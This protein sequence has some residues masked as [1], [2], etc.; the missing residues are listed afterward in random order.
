MTEDH[1]Q[2]NILITGAAGALGSAV[3]L[4]CAEQGARVLLV[5]RDLRGLEAVCDRV[6]AIGATGPGYCQLDLATAGPESI[7]ELVDQ[8]REA[9][10]PLNA[11]VHSAARFHGLQPL[12]QVAPMEWL[13]ALQ[14]N[15]N[16]AWLLSLACLPDLRRQPDSALLFTLDELAGE[17]RAYWGPYGVS[18]G[19]LRSLVRMFAEELEASACRVHGVDPGPLRSSL[20]ASAFHSENPSGLP[21]PSKA[22]AYLAALALGMEQPEDVLLQFRGA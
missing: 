21:D 16:S 17:G 2:R 22:G 14:V 3:A 18:K 19:A 10:G 20:R 6:E 1:K 12:D 4:A 7:A 5:D 13:Q 8:L 15:L 9:Y 11:L